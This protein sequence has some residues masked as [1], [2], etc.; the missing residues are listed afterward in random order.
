M[1]LENRNEYE[2]LINAQSSNEPS[3]SSEGKSRYGGLCELHQMGYY[4]VVKYRSQ[5]KWVSFVSICAI[6]TL[7]LSY[8][9]AESLGKATTNST[10]P[11]DSMNSLYARSSSHTSYYSM[12][13]LRSRSPNSPSSQRGPVL[14]K[15]ISSEISHPTSTIQSRKQQQEGQ[16]A[17]SVVRSVVLP[18]DYVYT[19][20]KN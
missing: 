7:V 18:F 6:T 10:P 12:S 4:I 20:Q 8:M 14:K 15:H 9:T 3:T 19:S 17:S 11:Q 16:Y 5:L 2:V 13:T 1:E